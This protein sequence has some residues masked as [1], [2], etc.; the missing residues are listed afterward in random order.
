[1]RDYQ[2]EKAD[3]VALVSFLIILDLLF[4]EGG[5]LPPWYHSTEKDLRD[6]YPDFFHHHWI[7]R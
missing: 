7:Q 1:M 2:Q 4:H 5:T 3:Y 6:T